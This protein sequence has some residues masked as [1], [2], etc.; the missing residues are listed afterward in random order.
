MKR[1]YLNSQ[2]VGRMGQDANRVP[3][4]KAR[5]N[6]LSVSVLGTHP[7][8]GMRKVKEWSLFCSPRPGA[9]EQAV[10]SPEYL[11]EAKEK[12]GRQPWLWMQQK[13]E[14]DI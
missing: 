9:R 13:M 11:G 10:Q 7:L 2:Q 4:F 6:E 1:S 3:K 12:K 5:S 14:R 8:G